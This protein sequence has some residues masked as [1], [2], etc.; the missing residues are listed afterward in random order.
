[1][2]P[3]LKL[4]S[5]QTTD[6]AADASRDAGL[7]PEP[8]R[9][10]RHAEERFQIG[11]TAG[12]CGLGVLEKAPPLGVQGLGLLFESPRLA[13]RPLEPAGKVLMQLSFVRSVGVK[14][15]DE[16]AQPAAVQAAPNDLQGGTLLRH[17]QDA[18]SCGQRGGD[19]IG[20][21]LGLPGPRRTVNDEALVLDQRVD[22]GG[23][24]GAI[25]IHDQVDL[26]RP[27]VLVDVVDLGEL[28][29]R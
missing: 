16:V 22:E 5:A 28:K 20:D 18:L 13:E 4:L 21:R 17:E 12:P 2:R 14:L 29:P 10:P 15:E 25:R 1:M 23:V 27:R 26:L 7:V 6:L 8:A 24:L 19:E 9:S 11:A 3:I